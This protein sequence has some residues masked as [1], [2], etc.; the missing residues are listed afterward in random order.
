MIYG[1]KNDVFQNTSNNTHVIDELF[2]KMLKD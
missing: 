1:D 2:T